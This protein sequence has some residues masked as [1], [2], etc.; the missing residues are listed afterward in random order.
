V[1]LPSTGASL[2]TLLNIFTRWDTYCKSELPTVIMSLISKCSFCILLLYISTQTIS[3]HI[4]YSSLQHHLCNLLLNL[5]LHNLQTTAHEILAIFNSVVWVLERYVCRPV[6]W[7]LIP[8]MFNYQQTHWLL[9]EYISSNFTK[10]AIADSHHDFTT[11]LQ[12]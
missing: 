8:Q 6:C 4:P 7:S 10:M 11:A 5:E 2:I 3:T 1:K 12:P 9:V